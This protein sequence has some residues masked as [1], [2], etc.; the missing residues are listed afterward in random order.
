MPVPPDVAKCIAGLPRTLKIGAYDWAITLETNE[1]DCVGLADWEP[2]Y[3]RLWPDGLTSPSHV[4]GTVLH[5]CE[6]IIFDN[7]GLGH[8]KR[9]KDEREEQIV[10]AFETGLVSLF[11]DNPKFLT[12][13]KRWLGQ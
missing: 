5:E 6:H 7:H 13:M 2:H 1:S 4:V 3:I 12:W 9:G 11:R 8:L 10:S